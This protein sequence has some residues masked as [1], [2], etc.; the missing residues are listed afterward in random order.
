M[1]RKLHPAWVG[2]LGALLYAPTLTYGF[3][4]YDDPW[5]IRD[6]RL[7]HELSLSSVWAVFTDFS[8]ARRYRLGAEYLPV[9]DL[10]VMVDYALYGDWT[11][12]HHLTQ[13][14][15]Y[16][17]LCA[18][19]ATFVLML[20]ESRP[21]AWVTGLLFA[22]HPVHV[23]AVCW[24]SERKG[25]LGALLLFASF[26]FAAHYLRR[27]GV[28][29]LVASW[30]LF[31]MSIWSKGVNIAG[32][33]AVVL[34]ALVVDSIFKRRAI[35]VA[36]Y[37]A[38]GVAA[39]VPLYWTGQAMK[40]VQAHEGS[41]LVDPLLIFFQA[42]AKY[43]ALMA[44]G[45]PYAIQYPLRPDALSLGLWLF[46]A[47]ACGAGLAA[48]I[49]AL[50][51]KRWRSAAVFGVLWWLIFLAPVSQLVFPLQN[52]LADR[53]LFL[54]SFG[55]L[56]AAG[57][58]FLRLPQRL[59][60]VPIAICVVLGV[61]WTMAQTPAWASSEALYEQA[62]YVNPH[63]ADAWEKLAHEAA[64]RKDFNRAWQ[65][66]A[67]GLEHSPDYWRLLHRQALILEATGRL[68]DATALMRRAASG[69]EAHRA[70]ANLALLLLRQ[71]KREEAL[72]HAQR[73][74]S[75]QSQ[76][77]H[78]HRTLGIVAVELGDLALACTAFKR[79]YE[80]APDNPEN[81]ENLRFCK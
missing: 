34:V 20:F 61:A 29:L 76:T 42:H 14:L 36:G 7:L 27:G 10:S 80:L 44:Y 48:G 47:V 26:V 28:S 40:M 63:N 31:L 46:G 25:V 55:L 35:L 30:L 45:G 38:I 43:L 33:A 16:G 71:G 79:A 78:N 51:K 13:V 50:H 81:Q 3:V 6:N 9:R 68:P 64:Q 37:A 18:T 49:W 72:E 23:E 59:N 58:L 75:Y 1:T 32:A 19:I 11:G 73:A 62:V 24:L 12:G 8:W 5:L 22:T 52:Y 57:A 69:P 60:L 74:V 17:L 39:F 53:Y 70:H 21:L 2:L 77:P 41:G 56:L 67:Q 66:A 65:L 54:P 15:L 4:S